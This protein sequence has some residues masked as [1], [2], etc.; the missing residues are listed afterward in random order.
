MAKI[1]ANP[2]LALEKFTGLDTNEE[3]I[4]FLI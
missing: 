1:V 3:G 2:D 4:G